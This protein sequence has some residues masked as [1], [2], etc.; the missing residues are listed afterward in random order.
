APLV[1]QARMAYSPCREGWPSDL[2]ASRWKQFHANVADGLPHQTEDFAMAATS[3]FDK[4]KAAA[5]KLMAQAKTDAAVA[6]SLLSNP[7]KTVT[8]AAGVPLPKGVTLNAER[9]GKDVVLVPSID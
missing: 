9:Q 1:I 8:D 7:C 5:D 3:D 6:N 2:I 4:L